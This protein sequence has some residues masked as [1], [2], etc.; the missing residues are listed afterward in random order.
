MVIYVTVYIIMIMMISSVSVI[1]KVTNK[2]AC[3]YF[4][5]IPGLLSLLCTFMQI[6]CTL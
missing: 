2:S 4:K 5:C 6:Y 3:H 1:D